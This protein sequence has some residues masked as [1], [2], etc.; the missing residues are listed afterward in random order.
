MPTLDPPSGIVRYL[1][2]KSDWK[3]FLTIPEAIVDNVRVTSSLDLVIDM[4]AEE[5]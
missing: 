4:V 3:D 2:S 1:V 5:E